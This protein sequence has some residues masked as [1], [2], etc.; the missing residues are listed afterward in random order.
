MSTV[1]PTVYRN[2]K[3]VDRES[4]LGT[5]IDEYTVIITVFSREMCSI[6]LALYQSSEL[7]TVVGIAG[8]HRMFW[9]CR[10]V[11]RARPCLVESGC[12]DNVKIPVMY[13]TVKVPQTINRSKMI[14][15]FSMNTTAMQ[16][17][18]KEE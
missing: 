2:E 17:N 5:S 9:C 7:E 10:G 3:S 13:G 12:R 18:S 8:T 15:R 14:F 6:E 11:H 4:F 16:R 1:T